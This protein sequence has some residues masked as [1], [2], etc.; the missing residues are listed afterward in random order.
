MITRDMKAVKMIVQGKGKEGDEAAGIKC[1][2]AQQKVKVSYKRAMNDV[3]LI[4]ELK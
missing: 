1:P 3:C 2:M 4:I